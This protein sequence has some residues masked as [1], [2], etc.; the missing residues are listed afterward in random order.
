[1]SAIIPSPARSTAFRIFPMPKYLKI[2]KRD[3]QVAIIN[4]LLEL[5]KR[6]ENKKKKSEKRFMKNK[7]TKVDDFGS[8]K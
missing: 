8:V 4:P 3:K 6:I 2:A 5:A 7:K 1:M